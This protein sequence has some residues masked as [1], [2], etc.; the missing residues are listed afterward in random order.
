MIK[1]NYAKKVYNKV[2]GS[3]GYDSKLAYGYF[4]FKIT[5]D[6]TYNG[7]YAYSPKLNKRYKLDI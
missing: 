5:G 7:T 2:W 4:A 1:A 3:G 6:K